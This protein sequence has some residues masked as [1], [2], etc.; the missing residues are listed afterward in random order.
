MRDRPILFSTA[1][2]QAN[3]RE[4]KQPGTGKTN[5]RRLLKLRGY[6]GFFQFGPSDTPG[7]DWTFRRKDHVWEDYEHERLLK[8]LPVQ[9]GDRLWVRETWSDE[10]PLAVQEGRYSQEGRAGIPGPPNVRY[11]TI[12][13][14][15]GEPLQVWRNSGGY[16]YFT[17]A[18]PKDEI[19]SKYPSV[20]SNFTNAKGDGISW[21]PSIHMPR[22]ASR[23]TLIVTDV[24]VERLQ[25]INKQDAIAEGIEPPAK[26][27]ELYHLP[28]TSHD[29]AGFGDPDPRK[30]FKALWNSLNAKRGFGWDLNPWVISIKYQPHLCNI[31]DL[32]AT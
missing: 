26:G 12:Y 1:M 19:A 22:W 30:V 17:T 5:T 25:E 14:A 27:N 21:T 20:S 15:D 16:P 11:R 28:G 9:I 4:I 29:L 13:K 31:D 32:V 8:L 24:Q 2:V 18:G 7:Y 23:I 10:H 6:P 3:L